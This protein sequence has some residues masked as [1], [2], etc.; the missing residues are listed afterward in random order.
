MEI[1]PSFEGHKTD[2]SAATDAAAGQEY[3]NQQISDLER[4]LGPMMDR[5]LCPQQDIRFA[6]NH[7]DGGR[8]LAMRMRWQ[9]FRV[10]RMYVRELARTVSEVYS[11]SL[12]NIDPQSSDSSFE[13]MFS[14][15][16][17]TTGWL[18]ILRLCGPTCMFDVPLASGLAVAAGLRLR[19]RF[20]S[21]LPV[22]V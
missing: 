12:Q 17:K 15:R 13:R 19:R 3:V 16:M 21:E 2:S 1:E 11:L 14:D 18:M 5:V 8:A 7:P 6:A 4:L 22:F 9:R 10:Y 20:A